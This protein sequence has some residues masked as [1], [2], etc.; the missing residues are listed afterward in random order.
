MTQ[1]QYENYFVT[2]EGDVLST[3]SGSIKKLKSINHGNGYL[4]I[5]IY[6]NSIKK[7]ISVHRLVA[8][9]LIPNPQNKPEVNHKNGIKTDNRVQNLEWAT[10][11]ENMN[12]AILN[13]LYK[14]FGEN[15]RSSKLTEHQVLEIRK[16]YSKKT[17]NQRKL[18][19]MYGVSFQLI[20]SIIN[21]KHWKHI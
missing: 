3:K 16:L 8:Q 2:K 12:H 17:F 6:N 18:A 7:G 19:E 21:K 11:K 1:T 10:P 4:R 13:G 15:T 9:T 20:S 14:G 5:N